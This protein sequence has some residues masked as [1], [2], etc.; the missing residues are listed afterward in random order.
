MVTP[1]RIL[2]NDFKRQWS[3]IGPDV[4]AAVERVGASGWYVLGQSVADFERALASRMERRFAV[5]CASGLDAIEIALRALALPAGTRVLT[6]PLSAFAT[7]LAI[8]RA[9]CV[10]VFADVDAHGN[11]DLEICARVLGERPDLRAMVPVHLY[12]QPLDLDVLAD[13]KRRFAL[14]I[15]EDCAQ[16]I[17]ARFGE[18]AAG[19]VGELAATSF[20]PTKNLGA[21][22]DGGALLGDD[23]ALC[24][25]AAALRNYGQSSRYVHD[26]LGLNSRLDELHAAILQ[27]AMLP[28][29]DDW[30]ARRRRV[31][32]RY[33]AGIRHAQ[34]SLPAPPSR[35]VPVWHLFPVLVAPARRAHLQ[36]HLRAAAVDSAVHYPSLL[37]DQQALAGIATE[38]IGDLPRAR[39]YAAGEVSLPIHPFLTDGEVDRVI[40]A[41]NGW[42]AP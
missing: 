15:V 2:L 18:R 19:T 41:V 6:T 8:V 33:L 25:V 16:S 9:G 31:A 37:P 24:K 35:A 5:G 26:R 36:D 27:T 22:G 14:R 29:L 1:D 38:V 12:G 17:G 39:Q 7:T 3:D 13:L 28:R 11:L 4:L 23:E 42:K 32:A 10:P 34:V 20:Y 40:D 30:T 21:L